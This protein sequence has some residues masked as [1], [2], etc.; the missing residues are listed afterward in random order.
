MREKLVIATRGSKLALWQ[1]NHVAARLR[2][3]HPGL[4]VVLVPMRAS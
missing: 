1:A 2:Q 3:A 4:E